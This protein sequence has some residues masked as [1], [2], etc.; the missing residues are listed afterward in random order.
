MFFIL[1]QGVFISDV[2][3]EFQVFGSAD[4]G[5]SHFEHIDKVKAVQNEILLSCHFSSPKVDNPFL[6]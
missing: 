2:F 3:L 6:D 4:G 1:G 5:C